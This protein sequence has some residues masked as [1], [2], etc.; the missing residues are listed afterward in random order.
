[1]LTGNP[2]ARIPDDAKE[3]GADILVVGSHGRRGLTRLLMGS[4][5]EAIALHAGC[6]VEVIRSSELPGKQNEVTK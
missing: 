2:K 5:S 1:M 6:S 4:V 3:W